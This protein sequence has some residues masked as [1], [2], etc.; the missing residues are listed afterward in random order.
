M[1]LAISIQ[2]ATEYWLLTT[3]YWFYV[4]RTPRS[5]CLQL[6]RRSFGSRRTRR[7]MRRAQDAGNGDARSR[8]SVRRAALS[9]GGEETQHQGAHRGR[10]HFP[11][12]IF[13]YGR[14]SCDFAR[15]IIMRRAGRLPEPLPPGD[16]H[17]VA[18]AKVSS[19]AASPRKGRLG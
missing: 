7:G 4:S 6:S 10:D 1:Q 2:A 11:A 9:S 3:G 15:V 13:P 16:S 12:A 18:C 19:C 17:E 14:R 8:W 5:L